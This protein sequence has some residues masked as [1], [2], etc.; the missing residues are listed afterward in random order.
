M[1]IEDM[2]QRM[3]THLINLKVKLNQSVQLVDSLVQPGTSD[4]LQPA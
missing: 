4:I 3:H 1:Y 2:R